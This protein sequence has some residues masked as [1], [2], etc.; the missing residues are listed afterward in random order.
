MCATDGLST[1]VLE[2]AERAKSITLGTASG[3]G[4]ATRVGGSALKERNES[5]NPEAP[6]PPTETLTVKAIIRYSNSII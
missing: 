6:H 1:F 3:R 2:F 4:R 5:E